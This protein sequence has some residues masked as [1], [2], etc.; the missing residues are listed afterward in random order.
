[1]FIQ[2]RL[3]VGLYSEAWGSKR[4]GPPKER[5]PAPQGVDSRNLV[6]WA[7][8]N[9]RVNAG[10]WS[11]REFPSPGLTCRKD[12]LSELLKGSRG[13]SSHPSL[14]KTAAPGTRPR[15]ELP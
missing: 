1:M 3:G 5:R 11:G 8:G 6:S 15:P 14:G 2:E 12:R 13:C 7:K 9:G 10:D 4:I